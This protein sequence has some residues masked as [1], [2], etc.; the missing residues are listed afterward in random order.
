MTFGMADSECVI[1]ARCK[2]EEREIATG[3]GLGFSARLIIT[4]QLDRG[5]SERAHF[6]LHNAASQIAEALIPHT[7]IEDGNWQPWHVSRSHVH[8][9]RRQDLLFCARH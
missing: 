6:I 3:I 8:H 1:V 4:K 5:A 7:E 2:I 9:Q